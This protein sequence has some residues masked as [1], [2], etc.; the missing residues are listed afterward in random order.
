MN[1]ATCTSCIVCWK[2]T[3]EGDTSDYCSTICEAAAE[4]RAPYLIELPRGHVAF[5]K[6]AFFFKMHIL[7]MLLAIYAVVADTYVFLVGS[8]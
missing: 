7:L 4:S 1:S 2:A 6:G 5:K 3:K 8:L